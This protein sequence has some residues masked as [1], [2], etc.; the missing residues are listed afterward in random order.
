[1]HTVKFVSNIIAVPC[2]L[3]L[4]GC[5]QKFSF[6]AHS[7]AGDPYLQGIH[8]PSS[9]SG[10]AGLKRD[11]V[12]YWAGDGEQGRPK[13]V[14][15]L[16]EQIAYFYKGTKLVGKS[17]ISSGSEGH[18]TPTGNFRITEKD[19]DHRSN[20]YG[21]FKTSDGRVV[22]NDVDTRK[23]LPPPR[24]LHFEGADM[25]HFMRF[26]GAIGMHAGHLPGYPASHGCVR[27]P[28]GMAKRFFENVAIGTPVLVNP[29]VQAGHCQVPLQ[30]QAPSAVSTSTGIGHRSRFIGVLL[31][32][33]I[34]CLPLVVSTEF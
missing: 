15:K 19:R 12:S 34:A 33:A 24:G 23:D 4:P 30:H 29:L 7:L 6:T 17:K 21:V 26:N 22:N 32:L 20:L 9:S 2:L 11:N 31:R 13:I 10:T 1:M 16:S 25:F 5:S 18:R 28:P 3:L 8:A 14:I 27:M